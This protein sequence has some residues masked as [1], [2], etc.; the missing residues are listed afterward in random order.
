MGLAGWA[1][2]EH[3]SLGAAGR[4]ESFSQEQSTGPAWPLLAFHWKSHT[5]TSAVPCDSRQV[6]SLPSFR[7]GDTDPTSQQEEHPG[8]TVETHVGQE[9][10][11]DQ[12]G[13]AFSTAGFPGSSAGEGFGGVWS[14]VVQSLSRVQLSVTPW[15]AAH[16][17]SLSFTIAQSLLRLMSIE[18]DVIQPSHPLSLLSSAL[19]LSQHQGS[20]KVK[21]LELQLLHQSFQ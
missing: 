12:P 16:Q 14:A 11:L 3:S 17:A 8:H 18:S 7:G 4:E 5:V 10:S 20:S 6:A 21:V 15:P 1:S 9:V 13:N 2:P 19:N